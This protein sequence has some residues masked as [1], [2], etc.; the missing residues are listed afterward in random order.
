MIGGI[1]MARMNSSRLPGK[2]MRKLDK[3][4]P[5]L[6]Y[7]IEQMKASK[8]IDK[9]VIATSGLKE[10]DVIARFADKM[11]IGY[12]RGSPNDV[13]DRY[14]Q[15][16]KQFSFSTI[17]KLTADNPIND[18]QVVDN[19]IKKFQSGRYDFVG[20]SLIHSYPKGI[21]VEI[22]SFKILEMLWRNCKLPYDREHITPYLFKNSE[23]FKI[24]NMEYVEDISHIRLSIDRI[25]DLKLVRK[26]VSEI[27]K[28][29]ILMK[30][31]LKLFSKKPELLEINKNYSYNEG[32]YKI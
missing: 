1:I 18:P 31:I 32:Y 27:T 8:L 13:V 14:Y 28:R 23:K 25:N 24:F 5:V 4:N 15:C 2:V 22:F 19:A 29:P 20:T 6:Y 26:V 30:D 11:D 3:K 10:D 7:V 21:N 16:A 17:L 9:I 12:Y